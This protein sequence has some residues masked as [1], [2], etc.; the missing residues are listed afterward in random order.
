MAALTQPA[1]I[2]LPRP[3]GDHQ[4]IGVTTRS[5]GYTSSLAAAVLQDLGLHQATDLIGGFESLGL[6]LQPKQLRP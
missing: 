5:E 4:P 2:G 1:H 6:G 3:Q